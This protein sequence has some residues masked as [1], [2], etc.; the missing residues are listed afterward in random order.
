MTSDPLVFDPEKRAAKRAARCPGS[1]AQM[2]A[3]CPAALCH[4]GKLFQRAG[5]ITNTPAGRSVWHVP[6]HNRGGRC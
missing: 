1:M 4:C 5:L 3:R 2:D 6:A